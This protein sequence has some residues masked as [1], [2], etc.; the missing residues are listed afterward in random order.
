MILSA[1]LALAV[2]VA[3]GFETAT[4]SP[5]SAASGILA[6]IVSSA[7]LDGKTY[8]NKGIVGFGYIPSNFR[9]STGDTL[10][11]FGSAIALKRG[12]WRK[13]GGK[14]YGTL[15]ARPDRGYN[16]VATINYQ[17]RQHEIDFVL[18][19]YYES[20]NQTLEAGA[21]SL[22]LQYKK[23][24]LQY[25]RQRKTTSGLDPNA[26]RGA[27][28]GFELNPLR[29]PEMPVVAKE[30][31][32]LSLDVEGL[33]TNKDGSYWISDEYGPYI[34]RF[35]AAGQLLQ[36]I[37]PPAAVLPSNASGQ[38]N[39]TSA[40]DPVTGRKPNQG[41]ENLAFD[42]STSTLYAMLQSATI[43]DGG[44][45]K[46][47]SR[48]TR[49]F[50]YNVSHRLITPRL[51]GE[52]VIPLPQSAKG[53]TLAC[54]E[55]YWVGDSKFLALSRDGDGRGGDDATSKYKQA[56]L[57]SIVHATDI[58]GTKYDD[59]ANPISPGGVL[60]PAITPATYVPFVNY[61]NATQLARFGLHNGKPDD[62][63]L[64]ASKWESFALAPVG[65]PAYPNDY[66]MITAA[67]NDFVSTDGIALGQPFNA[68]LDIDSQILVFRV[69][70]P[71]LRK[72]VVDDYLGI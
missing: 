55:T 43:Q 58:H 3:S 15:V 12:T 33:V 41:F 45:S 50:A 37:Q 27:Q 54:S 68:G 64:V 19:P 59:P 30:D 1:P 10:G 8:L 20:A 66:F 2:V 31:D 53:N 7:V 49:L 16:V 29:D 52:W 11:G 14:F 24:I 22:Q 47:K 13:K 35:S 46:S 36:T 34:Y 69:T 25:D 38:L 44:S 18:S 71:T 32:R 57:F 63:A 65:D 60:D 5:T 67:D 21:R 23:T 39:F 17:A 26:V 61:L 48:H 70:L 6:S 40:V 9:E 51:K 42:P 4:A 62:R 28:R 72:N 56:D